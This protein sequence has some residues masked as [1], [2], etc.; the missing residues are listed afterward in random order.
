MPSL[1]IYVLNLFI[2][3]R[4]CFELQTPE[5]WRL[6]R[7]FTEFRNHSNWT[8]RMT[9]GSCAQC[10]CDGLGLRT[11]C[12]IVALSLD[13][14]HHLYSLDIHCS[15]MWRTLIISAHKR[16]GEIQGQVRENSLN[17]LD[18]LV[19]SHNVGEV[20]GAHGPSRGRK[21]GVTRLPRRHAS[22]I[23]RPHL[24]TINIKVVKYASRCSSIALLR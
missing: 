22:H 7:Q 6:Q 5:P 11:V 3:R 9:L 21:E 23:M 18:S 12:G 17:N 14:W 15:A 13:R 20:D 10:A 8:G 24:M 16:D 1:N 2:L 19:C 4:V